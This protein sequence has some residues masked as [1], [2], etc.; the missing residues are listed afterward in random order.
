MA[1]VHSVGTVELT[2]EKELLDELKADLDAARGRVRTA[3]GEVDELEPLVEG[4]DARIRRREGRSA[5]EKTE[6][7]PSQTRPPTRRRR[8]KRPLKAVL[9][10]LTAEPGVW[11]LDE[12]MDGVAATGEFEPLPKL[13]SLRNRAN[14]LVRE[15]Y[16]RQPTSGLYERGSPNGSVSSVDAEGTDKTQPDGGQSSLQEGDGLGVRPPGGLDPSPG[17][18]PDSGATAGAAGQG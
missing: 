8:G 5:P 1:L 14:D 17:R 10:E 12:L 9:M 18:D 4:L 3:Q 11:S 2:R 16:L 15:S 6:S 13:V 7:I